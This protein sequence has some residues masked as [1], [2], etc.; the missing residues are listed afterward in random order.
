MTHVYGCGDTAL[1]KQRLSH[2]YFGTRATITRN[3]IPKIENQNHK[4]MIKNCTCLAQ[5]IDPET[6]GRSRTLLILQ[7]L[8]CGYWTLNFSW[9]FSISS[10]TRCI[11]WVWYSLMAPP[12]CGRTNRALNREKIRNISLAFF[13]VPSW[14]RRRAV[15]LVSTRSIL[16]S[17]LDVW[18]TNINHT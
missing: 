1:A 4:I 3:Q 17:Y 10:F 7:A 2:K 13:A 5:M 15:I 8:L 14:S 6:G 18:I 16:S 12:M 9:R 11:S